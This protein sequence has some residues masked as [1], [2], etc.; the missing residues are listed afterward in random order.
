MCSVKQAYEFFHIYSNTRNIKQKRENN[1][2]LFAI[3]RLKSTFFSFSFLTESGLYN[4]RNLPRNDTRNTRE[5]RT[6]TVLF[7]I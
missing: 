6:A 1:A 4:K 3:I 2:Q 7:T 5:D